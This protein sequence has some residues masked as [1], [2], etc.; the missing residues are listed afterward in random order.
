[1]IQIVVNKVIIVPTSKRK[2]DRVKAHL[3][4]KLL[5]KKLH[6]K[7]IKL[8]LLKYKIVIKKFQRLNKINYLKNNRVVKLRIKILKRKLQSKHKKEHQIKFLVRI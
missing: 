5:F 1:M 2:E 6:K 8:V 4:L 3:K 7:I